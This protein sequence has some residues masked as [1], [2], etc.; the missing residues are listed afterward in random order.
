MSVKSS[1][2]VYHKSIK[3]ST[4]GAGLSA[5]AAVIDFDGHEVSLLFGDQAIVKEHLIVIVKP[6]LLSHKALFLLLSDSGFVG[7]NDPSPHI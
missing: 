7:Q 1:S 6:E 2:L 5:F 4:C 3:E